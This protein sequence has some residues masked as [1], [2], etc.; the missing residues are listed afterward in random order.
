MGEY[1]TWSAKP[2]TQTRGGDR[3][4]VIQDMDIEKNQIHVHYICGSEDEDECWLGLES[5]IFCTI[6]TH[7]N[8]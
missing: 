4:A 8:A 6:R 3:E 7:C 1:T 5:S 2:K